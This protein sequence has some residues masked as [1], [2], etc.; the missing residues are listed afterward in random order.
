MVAILKAVHKHDALS[1]VHDVYNDFIAVI[2][3]KFDL[4]EAVQNFESQIEVQVAKFNTHCPSLQI[5]KALVVLMLFANDNMDSTQRSSVLAVAA[6]S[7]STGDFI[8]QDYLNSITYDSV[9]SVLCQCDRSKTFTAP[10]YV[11]DALHV[12]SATANIP[13]DN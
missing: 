3:F 7:V 4:S 1:S 12:S 6:S 13:F 8:T 9:A 11:P 10:V 5:P 2:N